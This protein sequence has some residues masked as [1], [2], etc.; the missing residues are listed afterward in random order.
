M[1][2]HES[3][4]TAWAGDPVSHR[5]PESGSD[6]AEVLVAVC[7]HRMPWSR[8][9]HKIPAGR[10][11]SS[12]PAPLRAPGGQPDPTPEAAALPHAPVLTARL[13]TGGVQ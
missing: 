8:D 9:T 10:R 6:S 4:A 7:G 5:E 12:C 11:S 3:T 13:A 1:T 2:R